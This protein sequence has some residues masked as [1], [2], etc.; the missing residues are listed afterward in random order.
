MKQITSADLPQADRLESVL[1]A[2]IAVA[3]GAKT[4][5]EIANNIPGIIGDDR[6]GRY[7]RNAAELLGFIS[8]NKNHASL[9]HKGQELI[10]NP[11]LTNSFFI[12]SVLNLDIYQKLLPYLELNPQGRTRK[13]LVAYISSI[14]TSVASETINRRMSSVLAWPEKLGFLI[15]NNKSFQVKNNLRIDIPTFNIQDIDQPILPMT[16]DLKEFQAIVIKNQKAKEEI[17]I[18]KDQV[19]VERANIVHSTLVN[20][21]A[22]RISQYGGIPKSNQLIDLAVSVQKDYIFEIKSL[23]G[24]NI[25][26]QVRKGIGQLYEYRYLQNK[27]SATLVLVVENPLDS[28]HSWMLDYLET[29]RGIHLVWDGNSQLYGSEKTRQELE[30]L[31]LLP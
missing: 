3:N 27:P 24:E 23:T 17:V 15:E 2:V 5:I 19:K 9:T 30:F 10:K 8:N 20:L 21:V 13:E 16:G 4:D 12:A 1:L 28:N 25:R 22:N 31:N 14:A 6:Q 18:L 11:V 7:Y 29:D 26:N